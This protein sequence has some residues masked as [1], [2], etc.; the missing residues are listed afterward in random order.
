MSVS[1]PSE[2]CVARFNGAPE[3]QPRWSL[4]MRPGVWPL[5]TLRHI[6]LSSTSS[7]TALPCH[8]SHHAG[9][10]TVTPRDSRA[11]RVQVFHDQSPEKSGSCPAIHAQSAQG[12][13]GF[14][15]QP[16]IAPTY[17]GVV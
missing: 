11:P 17:F 16:L 7:G 1:L 6:L 15:V 3:Q 4:V 8:S 14:Q 13:G 5:A 2:T 9:T 10:G 12:P